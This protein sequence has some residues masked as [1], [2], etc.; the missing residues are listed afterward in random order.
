M[1]TLHIQ[2]TNQKAI[3][4]LNE[5]EELHLIKII[6][7]TDDAMPKL[8]DKYRGIISKEK[9]VKLDEHINKMR[10]EWNSSL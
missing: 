3:G 9:G 5:L 8:S 7:D 10:T 1:E 4:L 6:K 2:V